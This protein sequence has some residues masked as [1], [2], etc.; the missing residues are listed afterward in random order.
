MRSRPSSLGSLVL[1]LA[2]L[3]ATIVLIT[4]SSYTPIPTL[5]SKS[6]YN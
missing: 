5:P 6:S 3:R 1:L 2:L 4:L